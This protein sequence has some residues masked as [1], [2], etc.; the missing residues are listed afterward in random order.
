MKKYISLLVAMSVAPSIA[1]AQSVASEVDA[2]LAQASQTQAQVSTQPS[3]VAVE[4]KV[5]PVT[6]QTIYIQTSPNLANTAVT[7]EVQKQPTTVIS[8]TPLA[9]SKAEQ[10]RRARQD[11][12]LATEQRIVEKLEAARMED[13]K[14]RAE[15]LFGT[16]LNATAAENQNNT[17][18]VPAAPVVAA[19]VAPAAPVVDQNAAAAQAAEAIANEKKT[20]PVII[21]KVIINQTVEDKKSADSAVD[22]EAKDAK[23]T[24]AAA[25]PKEDTRQILREELNNALRTQEEA[26]LIEE[27]KSLKYVAGILGVGAVPDA[28]NVD[29]NY[30]LGVSLGNKINNIII[31]GSFVYSNYTIKDPYM[32]QYNN[33]YSYSNYNS[34]LYDVDVNQYAGSLAAKVQLFDG[35]VKPVFGGFVSYSY[36][37]YTWTNN[38]YSSYYNTSASANSHAIDVGAIAGVDFDFNSKFSLGLDFR[39]M[40]NLASRINIDNGGY[41]YNSNND[42]DLEKQQYYIMSIMGRVNF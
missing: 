30:A 28:S 6:G 4:T 12:E 38:P 29:G 9:E 11:A 14:R 16:K 33:T 22:A 15:I 2:E 41:S 32:T 7:E 36:R 20:Q 26:L 1:L 21:E 23:V 18:V 13:E 25:A 42:A 37:D 40:W 8:S 27:P 5:T 19:P 17:T 39:Y 10:I 34:S 31:E 35:I 24:E 3:N